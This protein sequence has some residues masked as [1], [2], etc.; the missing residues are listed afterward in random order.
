MAERAIFLD[1]D[2]TII[3]D[4]EG[5]LGDPAKVKLLPGAATAI[6]SMRRLGYRIIVAS[7]QSGVARGLFT[8][9]DVEAVNDEMGKQLREQGGAQIDASYYCP[10]HP[11][12]KLAEYKV[13]HDWRKPK[14]GMLTQ[15]AEDFG[16]D[17][18]Q[19]WMIGDMPR[20]IACG[21]AAG[22][23]TILIRDPDH[24]APDNESNALPVS[25][26][27]IVKSLADAARILLREGRNPHPDL[28]PKA[29]PAERPVEVAESPV[30]VKPVGV[31][32]D[33]APV[34]EAEAAGEDMEKELP[35][36]EEMPAGSGPNIV[37]QLD[38]Q[39]LAERLARVIVQ[40]GAGGAAKGE[41]SSNANLKPV[42]EE[43]L[44]QLRQ[45]NRQADM[46]EFSLARL[47]AMVAQIGVAVCLVMGIY[48]GLAA[49]MLPQATHFDPNGKD[50]LEYLAQGI[51]GGMWL[52]GGVILQG[53]VVALLVGRRKS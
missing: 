12:A 32:G 17:L 9:A 25:P 6:A 37:V 21:A 18:G 13:D 33:V 28:V 50:G 43:I 24:P 31:P 48:D 10:Y 27:F 23:R 45:R 1:R 8:E 47:A 14:P 2:N 53:F 15:A 41:Q 30:V 5:Y 16:L 39:A 44:M 46:P 49:W 42:L 22:C 7:N 40:V 11:D 36:V 29:I 3:E 19:S 26:N 38:E 34:A 35:V 20:D 51:R 4:H 52:L